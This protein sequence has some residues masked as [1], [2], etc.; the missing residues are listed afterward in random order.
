ML[1]APIELL[2]RTIV[3]CIKYGKIEEQI[4]GIYRIAS[5]EGYQLTDRRKRDLSPIDEVISEKKEQC[6]EKPAPLYVSVSVLSQSI[7]SY[8]NERAGK[9]FSPK[10][11]PTIGHISGRIDE[12]RT[13]DDFKKVIDLKVAKWKGKTWPDTRKGREGQISRGD[14]FLCPATLF[15]SKNF[16]NYLNESAT[17]AKVKKT[18]RVL[19][20][21]GSYEEVEVET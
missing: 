20:R 21:D 11:K 2:K 4:S 16:E 3:V 6:S 9:N 8:L 17:P 10:S 12:G 7:I 14:D 1:C 15:C 5:W 13:L 19:Q 18:L